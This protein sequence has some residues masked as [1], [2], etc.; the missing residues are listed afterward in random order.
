MID[1]LVTGR[2]RRLDR[3][4]SRIRDA[5][6]VGILRV[7][8]AIC[9]ISA[10]VGP[11]FPWFLHDRGRR[12]RF[13][14]SSR[15]STWPSCCLDVMTLPTVLSEP[16]SADLFRV[17]DR[18]PWRCARECGG[19]RWPSTTGLYLKAFDAHPLERNG[20]TGFSRAHFQRD[21]VRTRLGDVLQHDHGQAFGD[22]NDQMGNQ[23]VSSSWDLRRCRVWRRQKAD[24]DRAAGTSPSL[25]RTKSLEMS[26]R[27]NP[28]DPFARAVCV[29]GFEVEPVVEG[30]LRPPH[31]RCTAP[32]TTIQYPEKIRRNRLR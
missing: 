30:H 1:V 16:I 28:V 14:T 29:E 7:Y 32:R 21:F 8:L 23:P 6:D 22:A 3:T 25:V 9:V 12:C 10:H 11:A 18:R 2:T 4:C 31:S 20:S 13:F 24:R 26:A 5:S 15:A 27:K 19:R 17:L